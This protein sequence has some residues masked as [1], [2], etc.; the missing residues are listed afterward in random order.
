MDTGRVILTLARA[1]SIGL[2]VIGVLTVLWLFN[3]NI[4]QSPQVAGL[5][6]AVGGFGLLVG[7][8][9]VIVHLS[10]D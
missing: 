10:R 7:M 1:Y 9:F 4:S 5:W 6:F 3:P 8:T 2:A